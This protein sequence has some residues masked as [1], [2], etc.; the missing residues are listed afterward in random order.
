MSLR[1]LT[2]RAVDKLGA[3]LRSYGRR[4]VT[5]ERQ[6]KTV[7]SGRRSYKPSRNYICKTGSAIAAISTD[8]PGSGTVTIY[9]INSSGVLVTTGR[10]ITAYNISGVEVAAATYIQVKEEL[11]SCKFIV[12]MEACPA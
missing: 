2:D 7:G 8:T 3:M 10:T 5:L 1:T 4:L 12:D 11:G 9:R 6:L